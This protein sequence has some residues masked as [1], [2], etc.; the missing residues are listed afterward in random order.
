MAP[1]QVHHH[2]STTK[3]ANKPF[4]TKHASKS[5]LKEKEK[6]KVETERGS[7]KTPHQQL[8]SKLDRRNQ[9]RQKQLLKQQDKAQATSIFT[10]QHGAPRHVAIVPLSAEI[11]TNAAI[12]VLNESVDITTEISAEGPTRVRVDRFRQS[13][14]YIKS[15]FDLV[16]AMDVCRM[17]DFVVLVLSAEVEVEEEGELLLRAIESQGI[18]NVVT[19]VQGLDQVNP[20]KRRPQVASSLK[21]FI[22]H[23]FPAVE[24]VMSLDSRQ[25]C[26]NAIRSLCTATPKGIRWRDERSWMF[27]EDVQWPN[28]SSEV[29]D[30]VVITGVVRG[31]GLKAD[32]IAHIPGWGDFQIDS[33]TAAPLPT[34]KSKRDDAMNV[35]ATDGTQVL[36]TPSADQDDMAVVAPEEIE[37]M[38]D[39]MVS[40]ADTEKKGV[41]L[42]DHHYFS[43][44]DSHIPSKPKRL[45]KGT[46]EYQSAWYLE[47]VSDSGSDIV[48]EDD[49]EDME[50]DVNGAPEDGFFADKEDAM[51]EGGPS[52][53]P[54]SEMFLDPSP[55]DE[56]QELEDYRRSRRTEA[57]EDLEFPDE[58][59]LHPNVLARERL[60]RFRGLK[61]MK[62]SPWE[63]SEDRPYEP[64]DW[65]RLLQFGDYKGTKNRIIREA[66]VGGVNPGVRVEVHLRAVPASL[67]H[68]AQPLSLFSLLRH[69]HKH[70]VVNVNM[71]LSSSVEKPIKSK[72]ELI[73]QIGSRRMVVNPVFS[74]GDNTPNNVHKFDRFLHPGRSAVATWIGPMTWGAVPILVFRNKQVEQDPEELESADAQPE[75]LSMDRLELIGTGT[76]IAPDPKRV[77]A[78]RAILTGHPYKIHKKV[79]TVRYMFFNSE[80]VQWFKALQLWT[81]RGRSGYMKESLGT[82]GYF[83]ATFDAKINPQDSIGISLYKRVFPRRARAL[84][85]IL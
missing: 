52:E 47:D 26:S 1:T 76:V 54:Q 81:R 43:D 59:E 17:A 69:E 40:V 53:Y 58:I 55:E 79:V 48:D 38:D 42:D 72:E 44:D 13:L 29:V 65:R 8:K 75:A 6:G 46:S 11:D 74:A 70:T 3:A 64:E 61:N 16:N 15:K 23:F 60:A 4:K 84:E 7:R 66:L 78:K 56:A 22:N 31:K 73:V 63:T 21:S 25:E 34:T 83:K 35:D 41:L 50:M 10:G 12:R 20:A 24:K 5:A 39:D 62:I 51:T 49:D 2:R 28:A 37:M 30:D 36:E 57:E 67:R 80:D 32:R 19:V 14:Q 33:I 45:P 18:S 27:I 9:A 68:K 71:T 82:H 85:E 77:I